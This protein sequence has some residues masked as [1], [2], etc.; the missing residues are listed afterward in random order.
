MLIV[1]IYFGYFA[2]RGTTPMVIVVMREK[3]SC[4]RGDILRQ[5]T[6]RVECGGQVYGSGRGPASGCLHFGAH[7]R[8]PVSRPVLDC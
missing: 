3:V 4:E 6:V 2:V 7:L 5:E 1:K 8:S